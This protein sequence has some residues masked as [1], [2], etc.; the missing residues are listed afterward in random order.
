[1][2]LVVRQVSHQ[3]PPERVGKDQQHAKFRVTDGT[4]TIETVWWGANEALFPTGTFDLAFEPQIN[5]FNGQR[6]VQ[7]KLLAWRS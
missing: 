6:S 7:L 5:E 2:Q 1:V 3:R 4:A